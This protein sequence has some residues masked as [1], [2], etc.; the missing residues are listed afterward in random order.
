[1]G[2]QDFQRWIFRPPLIAQDFQRWI[3]KFARKSMT[4][5]SIVEKSASKSTHFQRRIPNLQ[6]KVL[7]DPFANA[8]LQKGHLLRG[9]VPPRAAANAFNDAFSVTD[10]G[11]VT[12]RICDYFWF[13]EVDVFPSKSLICCSDLFVS[14]K[15]EIIDVMIITACCLFSAS[16]E[17]STSSL[18]KT[19]YLRWAY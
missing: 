7:L 17:Q 9:K 10:H 12:K 14:I 6:L 11:T 15:D 5:R 19:L 18:S 4:F 16:S 2:M 1:M 13:L 3:W 8:P